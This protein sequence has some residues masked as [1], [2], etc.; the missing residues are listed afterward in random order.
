MRSL[1]DRRLKVTIIG[2]TT[3][4]LMILAAVRV[5]DLWWWRSHLLDE[6]ER[7]AANLAVI[8][9]EY[10]R[11]TFATYDASLRQLVIHGQRIGGAAAREE[12]WAPLLASARAGLQGVGSV[13]VTDAS[14]TI[15]HTTQPLIKGQSRRD[16]YLFRQL[17][18]SSGD[19]LVVDRPFLTVTEP[20]QLYIPLGR[21]LTSVDR[22]FDGV[23]VATF[24]PA[25]PRRFFQTVDVGA[26]GMVWGFHPD[27][28]LLFREPSLNN[29]IGESARGNPIFEA[30]QRTAAGTLLG[31]VSP[32]GPALVTAFQRLT[33][34]PMIVAVSIAQA[35]V[36]REWRRE[37]TGSLAL[38]GIIA[39]MLGVTLAVL[40]PKIEAAQQQL[41]TLFAAN[42]LPMWVHDLATSQVLEVNDA[43]VNH[44]GYS[45]GEFL[46][47]HVTDID[48]PA[49]GAAVD[50][51]PG[52]R[53]HRLKSGRLIDV[54]T[55]T[56]PLTFN[57]LPAELVVA[58]DISERTA[59]EMQLRQVQ[60]MEAVGR[61]AGGVAHDFN[62]LLTAILGYTNLLLEDLDAAHPARGDIDEIRKAGESA[63]ALT[64]QLLAFS[65]KQILEPQIV[66]LTA[67]VARL[68]SL[69]QRVI[70][71][72]VRLITRL[73]PDLHPVN[74]DPG[75]V[76]QILINL[77]ANARDAMPSGGVLT[78]ETANVELDDKY[79]V[80]HPGSKAG[81]HVRLAVSDTGVGMDQATQ[82]Q[83][84][85][86]FFT[87]KAR[88][89]GTGLGLATVYGIVKQSGGWIWVDSR[90]GRG[91]TF[92]IY[93][94]CATDDAESAAAALPAAPLD[95][96]ETILLTEDQPE[97]RSIASS[98]LRRHGYT[99][100]IAAN[101]EEAL[102]IVETHHATIHLLLTDVVMPAMGGRALAERF[103]VLRPDI[104]VL[105]MSGYTDDA[106]LRHGVEQS[107]VEFIHKPFTPDGLLRK[108]R[109]VLDKPQGPLAIPGGGA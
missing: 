70:G 72:D 40:L 7:R 67:A 107:G 57:G 9:G 83:I 44:Y 71:E 54:D 85:E 95:G 82:T 14:G 63:A 102:A 34:P 75:Q 94:P 109:E 2:L 28:I 6:A 23:V 5:V 26:E 103:Q 29:P 56:H 99:V 108:I 59:L 60:K 101:A 106:I 18:S 4:L 100:L 49:D 41:K 35:E 22:T 81:P 65:R 27:G 48:A 11:E 51:P 97:V 62:N 25:E 88:G 47:M 96:S 20:R 105:Y 10:V 91:T 84:F 30:A 8:I 50:A 61:L 37:V 31:P 43:A 64:Q 58:Q 1:S 87:T 69:L 73:S 74:A 24:S 77:A 12:D 104:R 92:T 52:R 15:R 17:A 93:F 53:R 78:I 39:S 79:V 90:T 55:T 32:N 76:E 3:G 33:V 86:P 19:D 36:L 66:N 46:G 13:S 80:D 45:R 98:V 38:F 42:P 21:R 89:K 16:A 68:D